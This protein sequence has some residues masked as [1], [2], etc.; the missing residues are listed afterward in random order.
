MKTTLLT[1]ALAAGSL[2]AVQVPPPANSASTT[3]PA[4]T[5]K[6]TKKHVKK[7]APKTTGT[8]TA[9]SMPAAPAPVK[10]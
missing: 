8:P 9:T 5:P 7:V 10:K 2:F 4:V 1:I 3:K 6:K